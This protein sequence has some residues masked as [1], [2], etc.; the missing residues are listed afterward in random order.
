MAKSRRRK[1]SGSAAREARIGELLNDFLDR[2]AAGEAVREGEFLA[3]HPA[4]ASELQAHLDLLREIEPTRL[5]IGE[6]IAN[7]T[8]SE[9]VDGRFPARL[10][11]YDVIAPIGRGGM[12]IVLKGYDEQLKRHVAIKI[13]RPELSTDRLALMRFEQEARAA[14]ALQHANI[15]A[16]HAVGEERGTH[17]IVMEYVDGKTLAKLIRETGPLPPSLVGTVLRQVLSGLAAAHRAGLVHRD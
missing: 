8:L 7:G 16:V 3:N 13:L 1:E 9:P 11:S 10:G 12:G 2:K 15:I 17:F 14:A 6:L 4:L 5:A